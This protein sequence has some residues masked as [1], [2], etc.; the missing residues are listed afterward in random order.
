MFESIDIK[1]IDKNKAFLEN[2]TLINNTIQKL[3]EEICKKDKDLE[4]SNKNN[5]DE[6]KSIN[7]NINEL[8]D[9]KKSLLNKQTKQKEYLN[10]I[11]N[12]NNKLMDN[13]KIAENDNIEIN[14]K[15]NEL[16]QS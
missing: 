9:E 1:G 6:I 7:N 11:E 13:I 10:N 4:L 12:S 5:Q 14:K 16:L 15:M 2:V 8:E 3:K